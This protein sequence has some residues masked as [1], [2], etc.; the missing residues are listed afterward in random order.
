MTTAIRTH[1]PL[2]TATSEPPI[3]RRR[4]RAGRRWPA[5]GVAV[6]MAYAATALAVVPE[7]RPGPV[8]RA[9]ALI[10][11]VLVAGLGALGARRETVRAALLLLLGFGA[12]AVTAGVVA[13]RIGHGVTIREVLGIAAGIAGVAL[14]LSGWRLLLRDVRRRWLRVLV[15]AAGTLLVAQFVLL[16]AGIALHATNGP[17]PLASGRTPADL[18]LPF[19]DVRIGAPDGVR[20]AAWWIPS[21]NGAAVIVLHGSG[22]TRDDELDRAAVL[23]RAGYGVLVPDARGH[24]AS[25]GRA[26]E[27]GWGADRDVRAMVTYV[28]AQRSVT[29]KLGIVGESMGG[30][31][32]VTAAATDPRIAALVVEGVTAR[33]W[34][35]ARLRPDA[36]PVGLANTW[37]TLALADLL[38][39]TSPPPPLVDA[40]RSIAPRP[41]LLITGAPA[42]EGAF[43]RVYAGIAPADTTWWAVPDVPHT[44][45]LA[46]HPRDYA[47]RVLAFLEAHLLGASEGGAG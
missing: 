42:D 23:A 40:F 43:G 2:G 16:P 12:I 34:Q 11:I 8:A 35:D 29:G 14:V 45:A 26:M 10:A 25:E 18:G 39:P 7:G 41:V 5:A 47:E 30:E 6:I 13:G 33:T 44:G 36:H 3:P 1:E 21:G 32:A 15:A 38:S 4:G 37:L 27:F 31:V 22:S 9:L 19:R 17:R 24:G 46:A 28:L 20:L